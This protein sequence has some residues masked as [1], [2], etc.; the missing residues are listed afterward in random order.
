[1]AEAC[2]LKDNT[3]M[4]DMNK[5]IGARLKWHRRYVGMTQQ[6]YANAIGEQRS[7]YTRWEIGSQRL[8]LNGAL[9]IRER[10]GL[11]LDWLYLGRVEALPTNI[12]NAWLS[13]PSDK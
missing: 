6:E 12:S 9:A 11:S 3:D 13:S 5:D 1:M 2:V 4:E 7:N 10:F 8:S